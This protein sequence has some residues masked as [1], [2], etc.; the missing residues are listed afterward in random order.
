M[1]VYS[2]K[3]ISQSGAQCVLHRL[4]QRANRLFYSAI[5]NRRIFKCT[6]LFSVFLSVYA[7]QVLKALFYA[8]F[9]KL[10]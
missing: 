7:L 10:G 2:A 8:N 4:Q 5:Y 6:F 1:Y 9:R 3:N